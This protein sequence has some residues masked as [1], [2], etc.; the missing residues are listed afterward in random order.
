VN[1]VTPKP[2]LRTL[3]LWGIGL[4]A[5]L[6]QA[7]WNY[8]RQQGLGWAWALQPAL[9]RFIRDPRR[10][11]VR[12]ADHTAFFNTHPTMASLA[13]GVVSRM[14]EDGAAT[15]GP[16]ADEVRR[17]MTVMGSSLAALGDRLF[18]FAL[19][20]VAACVG[21][22]LVPFGPWT[23][24]MAMW[25][26]YNALHQTVR[27]AGVGWGYRHGPAVLSGPL[28][29]R[30]EGLR[31][32]LVLGGVALVGVLFAAM[33]APGGAPRTLGFQVALGGGL[34]FGLV[35]SQRPRP[36]PTEWAMIIGALALGGAWWL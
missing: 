33:I 34:A 11:A 16:E 23:A 27:F 1:D 30:L 18:W 13:L 26:T 19:R 14:E 6:L 3:D 8:E 24:A 25:L 31:H 5:S 4:R 20:P 10:R 36:S 17:A 32:G 29:G 15:G 28:R 7:T 9:R 21:L 12:L 35:A 22:M 2:V